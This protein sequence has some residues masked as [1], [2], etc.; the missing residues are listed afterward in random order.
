MN[1]R[2]FLKS[3]A[4][5]ATL[6]APPSLAPPSLAF[7][8]SSGGKKTSSQFKISL[9]QWGFE[10]DIFGKGRDNYKWFKKMLAEQPQAV[11]QGSLDPTDIVIKARELDLHGVDLVSS[12]LQAHKNDT[13]WLREFKSKATTYDTKFVCLMADTAYKIGDLNPENRRKSITEHKQWIDAA[14]ELA[15]EHLRVNPFGTGSYLQQLHHCTESL[16]ELGKYAKQQHLQLTIEN[17]GH[18]SSNGAWT[19][20]LLENIRHI[21]VGLFLDFGNFTMGGF[22]VRPRRHYD[23]TQGVLDL[24]PHATG[25]SA[26]TRAFLPDGNEDT[27]NYEWCMNEVLRHGFDGWVSAEYAGK[28]LSCDEGTRKTTELLRK[29]QAKN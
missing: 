19:N 5:L 11:L 6:L 28:D 26:K 16:E 15:C 13:V 27:I 21:N 29:F 3:S 18:P 14:C 25:I 24:A 8:Q 20:M 10:R 17:H 7:E 4:I 23:T 1:R 22:S 2:S 9:S 12:M